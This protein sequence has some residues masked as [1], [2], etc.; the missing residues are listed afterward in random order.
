MLE[1]ASKNKRG[2]S[3]ANAL[4]MVQFH[5]LD[6]S[7]HLDGR[8]H[9]GD[10]V[11]DFSKRR[12]NSHYPGGSKPP[13]ILVGLEEAILSRFRS[14]SEPTRKYRRGQALDKFLAYRLMQRK[15]CNS[16]RIRIPHGRQN[17][18]AKFG[19]LRHWGTL[20]SLVVATAGFV[21]DK[22]GG[23]IGSPK[24]AQSNNK[25]RWTINANRTIDRLGPRTEFLPV[26]WRRD[27]NS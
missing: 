20:G 22:N 27:N 6:S 26:A 18:A 19:V 17:I 25:S 23:S 21:V 10:L 8:E 16:V 2:S 3:P 15:R 24:Y 4:H 11:A 5:R 9:A 7:L 12:D 13:F 1:H 14:R